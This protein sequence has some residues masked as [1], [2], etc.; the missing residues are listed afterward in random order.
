MAVTP[1]GL[2][3][4]S[5]IKKWV[6]QKASQNMRSQNAEIIVV[7]KEKMEKEKADAT[8]S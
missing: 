1:F 3:M 8:A 4:P 7:L 5:D 2:R 6:E